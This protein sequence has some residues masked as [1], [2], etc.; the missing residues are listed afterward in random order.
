MMKKMLIG[1]FGFDS[2]A[3]MVLTD[4]PGSKKLRATGQNIKIQLGNM[5]AKA[6]PGDRLLFFFSGHGT[7]VTDDNGKLRQA[8]VGCDDN[9]INCLEFRHYVNLLPKDATL[10]I[11]A[12]S[13]CSGGL[14]D[15]EPVQVGLPYHPQ[16][17]DR[18][19]R[20]RRMLPYDA[21]LA[22]L[23]SRTGLNSPNIG[24]HLVQLFKSEASILFTQPPNKHPQPLKADQGILLSAGEPDEFTYED[25]DENGAPCG[26]FTKVVVE[27][28]K[29][30]PA[31][32]T[33]KKLV[34]KARGILGVKKI[35]PQHPCLYC[36]RKN[37][38]AGFL[39]K[40]THSRVE[41]GETS[42][43]DHVLQE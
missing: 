5:I 26:A 34:M 7:T 12:D 10:T 13:C 18:S 20:P 39:G 4:K 37:V 42:A 16:P 25:E 36:S 17:P 30:T 2:K 41:I 11:L 28:L 6:L 29:G 3:I 32:I 14:I 24:V 22:Q 40:A 15:Q 31:L 1:R 21:Y 23:S 35:N 38:D 27:I 8:I 43:E 19:C 9:N 33:N